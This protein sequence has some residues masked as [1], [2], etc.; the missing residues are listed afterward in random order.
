MRLA[1]G[2][3]ERTPVRRLQAADKSSNSGAVGIAEERRKG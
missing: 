3:A 1:E 2:R